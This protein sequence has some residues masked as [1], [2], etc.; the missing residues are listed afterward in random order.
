MSAARLPKP[1]T[2]NEIKLADV[3]DLLNGHFRP[4]DFHANAMLAKDDEEKDILIVSVQ[5]YGEL[6]DKI[7]LEL[8]YF[9]QQ[10]ITPLILSI[11]FVDQNRYR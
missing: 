11:Y 2:E 4:E 8:T 1:L 10:A 3:I 5:T 6:A 9:I 7:K